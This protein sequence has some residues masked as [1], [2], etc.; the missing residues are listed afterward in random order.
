MI[1][2]TIATNIIRKNR[3]LLRLIWRDSEDLNNMEPN[4]VDANLSDRPFKII[5]CPPQSLPH[6][7]P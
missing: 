1:D 2:G 4:H 6:S 7:R 5:Y 3:L